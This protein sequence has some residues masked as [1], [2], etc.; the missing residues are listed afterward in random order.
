MPC[1]R[2]VTNDTSVTTSRIGRRDSRTNITAG[3]IQ[4][5]TFATVQ[6]VKL[7]ASVMSHGTSPS[8]TRTFAAHVSVHATTTPT[9]R[10]RVD[11]PLAGHQAATLSYPIVSLWM[12]GAA[13]RRAG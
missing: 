4:T 5:I 13:A 10:C 11:S 2:A 12:P 3:T 6:N 9:K 1:Q 7:P 8:S